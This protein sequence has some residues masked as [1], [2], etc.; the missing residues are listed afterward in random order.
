[1]PTEIDKKWIAVDEY[2]RIMAAGETKEECR[3][4]LYNLGLKPD[5]YKIVATPKHPPGGSFL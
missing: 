2:D 1:M 5:D 3:G 4:N